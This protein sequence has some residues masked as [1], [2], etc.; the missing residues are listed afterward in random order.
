[1]I[2][3]L[4]GGSVELDCINLDW[5]RNVFQPL[6]SKCA[7]NERQPAVH[8]VVSL[9]GNID[10]SGLGKVFQA[11]RDVHSI[12][13]NV[14]TIDNDVAEVHSH[15]EQHTVFVWLSAVAL[16]HRALNLHR[17]LHCFDHA[18]ELGQ[19]AVAYQLHDA[20]AMSGDRGDDRLGAMSLQ[21]SERAGFVRSSG[22][23][24]R[25]RRQPELQPV[26]EPLWVLAARSARL[27][28]CTHSF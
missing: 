11:R 13:V 24:S 22:D 26:G 19:D 15:A 2:R 3:D 8:L 21:S 9:A 6:R 12:A 14:V 17:A 4:P 20:A 27:T 5:L 25:R 16:G 7:E 23:Y 18:F 1:M 28:Q 10:T